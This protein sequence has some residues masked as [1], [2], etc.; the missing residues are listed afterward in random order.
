MIKIIK[1]AVLFFYI[2]NLS[3]IQCDEVVVK[4]IKKN[5][6]L[7]KMKSLEFIELEK[8]KADANVLDFSGM[9]Y[10]ENSNKV[11]AFGGGHATAMFPNSVHE[12]DFENLKWQQLTPDVPPSQYTPENSVKNEAGEILGG[13]K[14]QDTIWAGSRHT[15]DG[16]VILKDGRLASAQAQE[17]RGGNIKDYENYQGGS[18]LWIFDPIQKKWSVSKKKGLSIGY[19]VSEIDPEQPDFIFLG[20]SSQLHYNK[21]FKKINWLTEEVFNMAACPKSQ[22]DS[23]LVYYPQRKSFFIFIDGKEK[24]TGEICEYNIR[25]NSWTIIKPKGFF[26]KLYSLSVVYDKVNNVFGAFCDGN[27]YYYSPSANE[28]FKIDTVYNYKR[29]YHHLI[30]S[31]NENVYLLCSGTGNQWSTWAFKFS[32]TPGEFNGTSPATIEKAK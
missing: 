17:F 9:V 24:G 22:N 11:Y 14:Y 26:P 1:I 2:S 12:F 31:S 25:E 32:D 23:C 3:K 15:Y 27:F 6:V 20:D 18:G 19:S 16:L 30:Y 8:H 29:L 4:Q 5:E 13:V 21:S 28:W 7:I 10:S